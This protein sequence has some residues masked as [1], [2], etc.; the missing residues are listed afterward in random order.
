VAKRNAR[1]IITSPS[2]DVAGLD[3]AQYSM[4]AYPHVLAGHPERLS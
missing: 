3:A 2:Q 1:V 4:L